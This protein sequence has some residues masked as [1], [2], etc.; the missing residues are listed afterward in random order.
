MS[1]NLHKPPRILFLLKLFIDSRKASLLES[2]FEEIYN[3]IYTSKGRFAALRWFWYHFF[4]SLPSIINRS[5][6]WSFIMFRNYL[7]I[8]LR[9]IKRQKVFSFINI[10]GLALGMA[11]FIL[12]LLWVQNE[13][14]YDKFHNDKEKIYR[15]TRH[16]YYQGN[17]YNSIGTPA[18]LAPALIEELPEIENAVRVRRFP[19]V[20]FKYGDN[21]FYEDKGFGVDEAFFKIFN[22]PFIS[23][24]P[25]NALTDV[26]DI[27]LTKKIAEKYFGTEDPI[28]KSIN[29]EG[30]AS[31]VV[32]G[33]IEDIPDNSSF[34]FDC[35]VS[36]KCI[37]A[38]QICG[39][40]WGDPNFWTFIKLQNPGDI[41]ETG[42]K[43]T[44]I[45]RNHGCPH[46]SM[47][48]G[49]FKVQPLKQV[50]LNPVGNYDYVKGNIKYVYIFSVIGF[51]ILT[52]ACINFVNL[53][54]ARY[55]KRAKEVGMRK[56]VGAS[57]VQIIKQLFG[58][59]FFLVCIS[60]LFAVI[61]VKLLIPYFNNLTGK[62]IFLNLLDIKV[63]FIFMFVVL[64][65]VITAGLYPSVYLSSFSPA[66]VLK[67]TGSFVSL[68]RKYSGSTKGRL[69]RNALVVI[70]FSLSIILIICTAVVF[71]QLHYIL[72]NSWK[73]ENECIIHI[74]VKENI[75]P[76]YDY[77]K[78]QLLRQPDIVSVT[79]KDCLPTSSINNTSGV[80]WEG[81]TTPVES[82]T[83]ET[84]RISYDYFITMGIEIVKGREFSK[85]ISSDNTAYI[86]NEEA[87][88][89]MGIE[90]PIGKIFALYGRRG[91]I[92]GI[93]K[94]TQFQSF[95][96]KYPPQAFH[97][98]TDIGNQAFEGGV[99]IKV[100]IPNGLEKRNSLTA[101]ITHIRNVWVEVN[102]LAP[103]EYHFLDE[104]IES[105]Y[106]NEQNLR[107]LF[108]LFAL[109]AVIISCLGLFGLASYTAE[110]R[111]K[112]IGIRKVLGATISN[113]T[114]M[115][116]KDFIKW[117]VIANIIAWPAAYYFMNKWLQG[118]EYRT[119][120]GIVTFISAGIIAL[121]IALV[122][123]NYQS[124]K[125]AS[126][127]P[128]KSIKYE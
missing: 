67:G 29:V 115:L 28:N 114:F 65:S 127:D 103:F 120:L 42:I 93:T 23:G 44:D 50:Y 46:I 3:D 4:S 75:G 101:S 52:I 61:L 58:E 24:N 60:L 113:I 94:N 27:V 80:T 21:A 7:K 71:N 37:E 77:V 39:L 20:I 88:S 59:S 128:V 47:R 117:V 100:K 110:S 25:E 89:Q 104:T 9:N 119:G 34:K 32:K 68:L 95:R 18:P 45:A 41:K 49:E 15:I 11:C 108:G 112:E 74:P 48:K 5:I 83:M 122:T 31:F 121:I 111:T 62:N 107:S 53:S 22:F 73:L 98:L 70:Q 78:E 116:T 36:Y 96:L 81:K 99:F 124:L 91:P 10:G 69:F 97:L 102:S 35:L 6:Y 123:V 12:I 57:R 86:L 26:F 38:F 56:V 109:L 82:L 72:D 106:N 105:L 1:G 14:S 43:I 13:L 16:G 30:R 118:F 17:Q 87:V 64:L 40:N 55:G 2:N 76:K 90:D 126:A 66:A 79:V 125:A 84:T 92:I 54:T 51:F 8:A 19:R 33:V 63:Y 85:E